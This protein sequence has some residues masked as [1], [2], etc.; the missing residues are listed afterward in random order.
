MQTICTTCLLPY[1]RPVMTSSL[2]ECPLC[3]PDRVTQI[4]LAKWDEF[5]DVL[6][7]AGY[8]FG[9]HAR[10]REYTDIPLKQLYKEANDLY[11]ED[12]LPDNENYTLNTFLA[13][14][15]RR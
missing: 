3:D 14:R 11:L 2:F 5:M 4:Q 12:L 7:L 6:Q 15:D 8:R 1:Q 10:L 9:I 13:G